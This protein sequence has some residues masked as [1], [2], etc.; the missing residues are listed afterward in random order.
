M[1]G[2]ITAGTVVAGAVGVVF[3]V[4]FDA[5]FLRPLQDS[6]FRKDAARSPPR[7]ITPFEQGCLTRPSVNVP[8]FAD[9]VA[10]LCI[11]DISAVRT[12]EATQ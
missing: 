10:G 8:E 4:I 6:V 2:K 9:N 11:K 5:M 7:F 3:G 1:I 12:P